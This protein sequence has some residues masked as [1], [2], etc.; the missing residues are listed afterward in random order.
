MRLLARSIPKKFVVGVLSLIMILSVM[1]PVSHNVVFANDEGASKTTMSLYD[2]ASELSRVFATDLAPGSGVKEFYAIEISNSGNAGGGIV[3]PGNAGAFLGYAEILNDDKAIMGWL[4]NAFTTASA[5]ITYD[6][7]MHVVDT[8]ANSDDESAI[9]K[10]A[11]QNNPFFQYAG[12]GETLTEMGLVKTTRG[13]SFMSMLGSGLMM[14]AYLLAQVAPFLFNMT[15]SILVTLNPF[16][17]FTWVFDTTSATD[18]GIITTVA[19]YVGE[20][21][22]ALQDFSLYVLLPVLLIITVLSILML[23]KGGAMKKMSR[24]AIRVF[25]IF[26][27]LP[28]LGATYTGLIEDMKDNVSIGSEYADYIVLSSYVDFEGWA[29]Y[30]RLAPPEGHKML[31]P[32]YNGDSSDLAVTSRKIVLDI[33]GKRA[34][35]S[36][37]RDLAGRYDSTSDMSDI[38][39]EGNT[40]TDIVDGSSIS[41]KSKSSMASTL[42]LLARHFATTTYTSS[43]YEGEVAGQIQRIL[44]KGSDADELSV[45]KM[46]TVSESENRTWGQKLPSWL[47]SSEDAEEAEWLKPMYWNGEDNELKSSA[48]GLFTEGQPWNKEWKM[49]RFSMNIYNSG[50]LRYSD[51]V[52]YH[53]NSVPTIVTSK[54]APIGEDRNSTV[55][56]LSPITMHNFLNT[57]FTSSGLTVFSPSKSSS[58]LTRDTYVSVAF[59]G[60]GVPMFMK[61]VES[62]VVMFSL[63]IIAI[64]YGF[65]MLGVAFKAIPR[66]LSGAFGTAIGS[67]AM[68]TKLLITVAVL[69]LQIVGTIFLYGLAEDILM[70]ILTGFD[71]LMSG[72]AGYFKSV[73][74][75]FEFLNGFLTTVI[76]VGITLFMIKNAKVF[77]NTFEEAVSGAI[78][79]LMSGLDSSTG[80]RGDLGDTTGGRIGQDGKLTSGAKGRD[81]LG[82]LGNMADSMGLGGAADLLRDA[83]EIEGKREAADGG[84]TGV[85]DKLKNRL[86]TAKDL[87]KAATSD[88]AK[89][90]AGVDGK[91]YDRAKE[92]AM[93]GIKA[94]HYGSGGKGG[95][96]EE[97]P[98]GLNDGDD[99]ANNSEENEAAVTNIGGQKVD[100]DGNIM[101]DEDGNAMNK[102]G[103]PISAHASP[104]G[105]GLTAMKNDNGE[106][107][108]SDN[109]VFTDEQGVAFKANSKGHLVDDKGKPV[110]LDKDG[111]LRPT[112]KPVNAL[113]AAK[114]L[115]GMRKN[116]EKF[117]AMQD[118]QSATHHGINADGHLESSKGQPLMVNGEN[119]KEPAKLDPRGFVTDSDGNRMT[120][121]QINGN[122]DKRGF[123]EVVDPETGE[124]FLQHKGDGAIKDSGVVDVNDT[125]G[126]NLTS[127]ARQSEAATHGAIK[128]DDRVSALIAAKAPAK[129]I[130]QAQA[131][132]ERMTKQA[133]AKSQRFA[134]AVQKSGGDA[135][136]VASSKEK[137]SPTHM[138]A[139]KQNMLRHQGDVMEQESVLSDMKSSGATEQQIQA[140][141]Q[142]VDRSKVALQSAQQLEGDLKTAQSTGR[143]IQDVSQARQQVAQ[144]E[145]QV[146]QAQQGYDNA[147][148]S[149]ASPKILARHEN[150]VN[151]AN[152]AYSTAQTRMDNMQQK[153]KASAEQIAK[154]DTGI[155]KTAQVEQRAT[156]SYNKLKASGAPA[157]KVKR[158][159]KAMTKASDR[160][161]NLEK[162][163]TKML[164]PVTNAQGQ[165]QPQTRQVQSTTQS[166][167]RANMLK[168]RIS[169][170]DDYKTELSNRKQSITSSKSKI[171]QLEQQLSTMQYNG[172][173]G[174]AVKSVESSIQRE[175]QNFKKASTSL[176]TLMDNAQAFVSSGDFTPRGY[177][178][179]IKANGDVLANR[180]VNLGNSQRMFDNL[181]RQASK[182]SLT[183]AQEK[184]LKGLESTIKETT[185][186]LVGEGVSAESLRDTTVTMETASNFQLS[187]DEFTN[188][189]A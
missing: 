89:G 88:K 68:I 132:A 144:S 186:S 79:R 153:P 129:Q 44:R 60:K 109:S 161:Q 133:D 21:Y 104:V 82:T 50:D 157:E 64:S 7:L 46:F 15:L 160:R 175:K 19:Q 156:R 128:A 166:A 143:T 184:Q 122:V 87:N 173:S 155:R 4:M 59:A 121:N 76:V 71:S 17:L 105:A 48:K 135:N 81:D 42:S 66:I 28:L 181:T 3:I 23:N 1:L 37:A 33:N 179:P 164:E 6:Q 162:Q 57:T 86:K 38:F 185:R 177:T 35:I 131:H 85:G 65:I 152:N 151:Q 189:D 142:K 174:T 123:N 118:A 159:E 138:V 94:G 67:I 25:M 96:N 54:T 22:K 134:N 111:V 136:I 149:G 9:I 39:T 32:R 43:D 169:T 92:S 12:Y 52:G 11:G 91:A 24:Y 36:R 100:D 114:K 106:L 172:A 139:A 150:R 168:N 115:D 83:N 116:P 125:K 113:V 183:S 103:E 137:V 126:Q 77:T 158:A 146:V 163:R 49:G 18:L 176:N 102:H 20:L 13:S 53:T 90:L 10:A 188:G 55:G 187:W 51:E 165:A 27:G 26:A 41:A 84:K 62:V 31:H 117:A 8:G 130:K 148:A 124:T 178:K 56:G 154:I 101:L 147:V 99:V 127:L 75:V 112:N 16:K 180:M 70:A 95:N 5:T 73:G 80:G 97:S 34:G 63:A 167:S 61:W 40:Q 182:G 69:I 119:G 145:Q 29:K 30:S 98:E 72:G 58:D 141:S 170:Y 47:M 2:R 120:K 171:G 78:N 110:A 108:S 107:I 14:I 93:E 45:M 74:V 140:Q